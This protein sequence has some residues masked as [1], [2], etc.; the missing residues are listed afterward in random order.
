MGEG[1]VAAPLD[2]ENDMG[3]KGIGGFTHGK[4]TTSPNRTAGKTKG[5]SGGGSGRP[6]GGKQLLPGSPDRKNLAKE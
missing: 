2:K 6:G 5:G 4:G 1:L 3:K